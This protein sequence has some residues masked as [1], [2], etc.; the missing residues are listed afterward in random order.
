M[1]G[2][3]SWSARRRNSADCA[4]DAARRPTR[5]RWRDASSSRRD[6]EAGRPSEVEAIYLSVIERGRAKGIE[7]PTLEALAA[8]VL[9][10]EVAQ[11]AA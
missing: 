1:P 5:A 6:I 4:H 11:R 8:L 2:L 3:R 9:G 7:T 10:V